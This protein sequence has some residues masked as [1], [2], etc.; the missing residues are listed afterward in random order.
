MAGSS[1]VF[2]SFSDGVCMCA[3]VC[4]CVF[5]CVCVLCQANANFKKLVRKDKRL[6]KQ[7]RMQ[8][9]KIERLQVGA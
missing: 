1:R 3:C 7:I 5:V 6:H 9:A 8:E 2:F 4:V